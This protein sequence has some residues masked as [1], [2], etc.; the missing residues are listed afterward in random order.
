MDIDEKEFQN[1]NKGDR[2]ANKHFEIW[3]KNA[4]DEWCEFQGF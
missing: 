4:F 2:Q 3:A 1:V